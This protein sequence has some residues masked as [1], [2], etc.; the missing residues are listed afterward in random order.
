MKRRKG[1]KKALILLLLAAFVLPVFADD[2]LVMPKGV[3][4]FWVAPN[5]GMADKKF[6]DD[7]KKVD[8][9]I[10]TV[11]VSDGVKFFNLALALEYGVTDWITAAVQWVPGWTLWSTMG[12][13]DVVIPGPTTLYLSQATLGSFGDLFV[14]AKVQIVGPKAPVQNSDMRFAAAAGVKVPMPG[15]GQI[16]FPGDF[17]VNESVVM[18]EIDHHLW[19]MG[20]R[21]YYDYI[22]N[23]NFFINLYN[24]TILYPEQ[25]VK[26]SVNFGD[27]SK[28]AYGYDLTF[29]LEPQYQMP[30]DNGIILKAGLPFTYAMAPETKIDGTGQDNASY[31][32]SIGPNVAAFFTKA[33]LPFELELQYKLPL[34]GKTSFA[35][36]V[37]SLQ[38][39]FYLKF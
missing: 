5:Y 28:V 37:V 31:L 13:D 2:A 21:L 38:G 39:K 29:E 34:M 9:D 18:A 11:A 24:E 8:I 16:N 25:K 7:G 4:R 14:G 15:A 23:P 33:F 27:D 36:H 26:K 12:F 30:L 20:V 17:L 6:D 10:P 32:F 1:M 35:M 3:F 19:G 22:I